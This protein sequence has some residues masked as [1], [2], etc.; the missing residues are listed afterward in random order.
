MSLAELFILIVQL[1]GAAGAVVCV[2]FLFI[3]I[4]RVDPASHDAY[5]FRPLLIPGIV[6]I[7]PLVLWRWWSLEKLA[8]VGCPAATDKNSNGGDA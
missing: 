3:G 6:V 5:A 1:W 4:D 2:L 7:W 8:R